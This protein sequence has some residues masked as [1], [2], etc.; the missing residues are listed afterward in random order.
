MVLANTF[1]KDKR[2]SESFNQEYI[3]FM[4]DEHT[5]NKKDFTRELRAIANLEIWFQGFIDT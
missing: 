5:K 4:I 2:R 1:M 3:N